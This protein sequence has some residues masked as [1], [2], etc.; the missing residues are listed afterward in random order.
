MRPADGSVISEVPIESPER[1]RRVVARVRA[2][3][4]AW[5]ALGFAGPPA[6]ARGPARL[7]AREP[8]AVDDVMQEETGKVRADAALEAFCCLDAI[9]F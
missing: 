3:Q 2:N 4:P 9:N 7:D 8:R 6:L 1:G 5:E